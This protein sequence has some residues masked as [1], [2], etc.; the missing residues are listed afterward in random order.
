M[1]L[2]SLLAAAALSAAAPT[3]TPF[4]VG[5]PLA[6][7]ELLTPGTRRYV[8]YTIK[9]GERSLLDLWTRT[10]SLEQ[11]DGKRQLHMTQKWERAGT[12]RGVVEQ[13]SWFDAATLAPFTH[14]R[15]L[16][17]D[18][19]SDVK[20][21]AFEPG[22][23]VGV[24]SEA[25]GA[26]V[27]FVQAAPEAPYNFEYDM[28]LLQTLP[29]KRGMVADLVFYDP[30]LAA[31]AHY[32]FVAAGEEKIVGPDGRPVDCWLITA[33][34]NTVKVGSRFWIAKSNQLVIHEEGEHDGTIYVKTL[35][36]NE[37]GAR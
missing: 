14:R 36:G 28:E 33:D 13:D 4:P 35:I 25:G 30:G 26:P 2:V 8:R 22:K 19:K 21:W 23:I 24:P 12:P 6:R 9:D 29:W 37:A 16:V 20:A 31:P 1:P 5:Q 11:R 7:I 32:K 18:G 27:D 17:R 34:Y 10:V 15:T 3:A